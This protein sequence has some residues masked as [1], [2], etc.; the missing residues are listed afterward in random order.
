MKFTDEEPLITIGVA[1]QKLGIA[2]P[3]M[4]MYEKAGLIIPHRNS[5]GRRMYSIT[6]IERISCIRK[7]IKEESLNLAGIRRLMALIPCWQ[8]K[9]C[10]EEKKSQCPA[11]RSHK[12]ICWMFPQTL[13]NNDN[14]N[15]RTC[16]VYLNSCEN[17][18][19]L[20]TMM[21]ES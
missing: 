19:N 17:I 16:P 10:S 21:C 1:A 7:L 6:D 11:F 12:K 20:K 18:E 5:S 9:P 13:C 8:L 3:T 2:V 15:C 4:R 14:E